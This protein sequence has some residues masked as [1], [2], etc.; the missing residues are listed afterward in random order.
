MNTSALTNKIS[1]L[2]E[3]VQKQVADFV[4]YLLLKD[5]AGKSGKEELTASQ[6]EEL[7]RLWDEYEENPEEAISVETLQEQT[8]QKY[9]L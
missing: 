6:K 1:L 9:G 7:L 3:D 2:P 8:S 5:Q 4:E